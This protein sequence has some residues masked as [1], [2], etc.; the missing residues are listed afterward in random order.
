[1]V[2]LVVEIVQML[3][4][5]TFPAKFILIWDQYSLCFL[6]SGF[7]GLGCGLSRDCPPSVQGF[8][9]LVLFVALLV[10][11]VKPLGD[12]VSLEDVRPRNR[13]WEFIAL[14]DFLSF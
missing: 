7:F 2:V 14:L 3:T 6:Y 13:S 5:W 11:T 10:E 8:E 4:P 12:R 9:H 1:M